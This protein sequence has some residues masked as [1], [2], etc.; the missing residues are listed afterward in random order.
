[1]LRKMKKY[2]YHK[3]KDKFF[4]GRCMGSRCWS[5]HAQNRTYDLYGTPL[6]YRTSKI[7]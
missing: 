2:K 3:T 1:M 4:S 5:C 6:L 7:K